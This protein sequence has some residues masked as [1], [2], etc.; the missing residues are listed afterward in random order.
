MTQRV[1]KGKL[2]LNKNSASEFMYDYDMMRDIMMY[3]VQFRRIALSPKMNC[4]DWYNW[5]YQRPT[6]G[7]SPPFSSNI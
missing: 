1:A 5:I 6:A 7:V 4:R 3:I 2:E